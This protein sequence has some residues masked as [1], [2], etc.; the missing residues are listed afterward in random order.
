MS[1]ILQDKNL[2][3]TLLRQQLSKSAQQYVG[4][5][6]QDFSAV[7]GI[8][9]NLE[10]QLSNPTT[11]PGTEVAT[12]SDQPV[13]LNS[14]HMENLGTLVEFLATNKITVDGK[15]VA[16]TLAEKV[17]DPTYKLYRLQGAA[18][19]LELANRNEAVQYG[20]YVNPEL[21]VKYLNGLRGQLVKEPNPVLN[22]QVE[23]II[24][25]ANSQLETNIDKFY[26]EPAKTLPD[27]QV[28]DR[29]PQNIKTNDPTSEGNIVLTYGD[30]ASDTS[31]NNWIQQNN[32]GIDGKAYRHPQYNKCGLLKVLSAR[33]KSYMGNATSAQFK[34]IYTTYAEVVGKLTVAFQCQTEAVTPGATDQQG[35]TTNGPVGAKNTAATL[36][37]LTEILPLQMD[38]LDFG[39]IRDFVNQYRSIV[40]ASTDSNRAQQAD[41]AITQLEQYM[42]AATQN[43]AG[44]SMTNFHMDGLTANDLVSW[45]TPPSSGQATRSRGSAKALADYLEY[46]VRNAY[47][48]VKDLYN[49]HYQQ[50]AGLPQLRNAIEQQVGGSSIPF[51][52]SI[53]SSNLEN[54]RAARA[55]LPQVGA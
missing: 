31:F 6:P 9:A 20:Y 48:L 43:T 39:R 42:Q 18:G 12:E 21:L 25:Q 14:A 22:A 8:I 4:V 10:K 38:Q 51:G 13:A 49:S 17:E 11:A 2:V 33:A 47:T 30:I 19:L 41:T 45:A 37:Q 24:Q 34:E 32:I 27:N 53:A 40:S 5:S 36:Q 1:F 16:Y 26:R 23:A 46:V 7:R 55:R 29:L 54:I 28:L 52:S 15:R 3:N 35:G 50:L 44:Q